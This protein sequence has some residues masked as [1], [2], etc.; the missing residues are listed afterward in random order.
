MEGWNEERLESLIAVLDRAY[1]FTYEIKNCIRGCY[2][3]AHT[4]E[5]LA[6]KIKELGQS[7][8]NE[9]EYMDIEED[10]EEEEE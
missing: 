1:E 7:L 4:Y 8:I 6:E 9:A 10:P 2:T 5:E 3:G